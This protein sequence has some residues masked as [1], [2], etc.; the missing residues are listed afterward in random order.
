MLMDSPPV[1]IS[2]TRRNVLKATASVAVVGLAAGAGFVAPEPARAQTPKRGGTLRLAH[3]ADP[4]TGFDPHQTISFRTMIPLSFAYSRL[5]KVKAGPSVRPM[6]YPIE[7]GLA[8]SRTQPTDTTYL[9]KLKKGVRWH[10]KPPVNGREFTADDVKYSV[11]RFLT[12]KGNPMAYM[13]KSVDRVDVVDRYT[14]KFVMKEPFSWLL[15]AL[16]TPMAVPI[17]ARECVEKFG[18]L[19]KAEAVVGTG[20]WMLETHRPNVGLTFVRHPNYFKAGLP[21][22]DRIEYLVDED[23]GSRMA[24][25]LAGKYDLGWEFPGSINRSD[26]VQ[27][28]ETLKQKRPHLRTAEFPSNVETHL[29]MRTDIPPFKDVRV[30]RAVSLALDRQGIIDA[31]YEGV[32]NFNP[33]IPAGLLEWAL[34]INQLGEGAKYFRHDPAEAKRLLAAAGFPNG[35]PASLCFTTYGSTR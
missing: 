21:Y 11:E 13:L 4:V 22:I 25:F 30:R 17:V 1:S 26:W 24:A 15:E 28:K 32:G 2:L 34:P 29:S 35:F 16:A 27:I 19:K 8:E 23:N 6:T 9:F 33:A 12:V 5:L 31:S 10:P 18:D 20:P 7:P 3:Q 14:V